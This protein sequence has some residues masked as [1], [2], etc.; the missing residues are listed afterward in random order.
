MNKKEVFLNMFVDVNDVIS[1]L[2]SNS[3]LTNDDLFEII[4]QIDDQ[5]ADWDFTNKLYDYFKKL[6]E[7]FLEE[8][9]LENSGIFLSEETLSKHMEEVL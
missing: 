2:L 7:R 6:N 3:D 9:K 4:K 1:S 5:V 8:E